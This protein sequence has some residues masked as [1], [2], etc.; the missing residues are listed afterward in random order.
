[1]RKVMRKDYRIWRK[2]IAC[3][4]V[5][6]LCIPV[7]EQV[8]A[9]SRKN[10]NYD[11]MLTNTE[12]TV[13]VGSEASYPIT[14]LGGSVDSDKYK[15]KSSDESIAKVVDSQVQGVKEGTANVKL[16]ASELKK[17][18]TCKVTVKYAELFSNVGGNVYAG[19]TYNLEMRGNA[20][21]T[22]Y[23]SSNEKIAT[24]DQD[25]VV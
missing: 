13:Y 7:G 1:M 24:V 20:S 3:I 2:I 17:T 16:Y 15:I 18:L 4:L 21:G 12:L 25:G 23:I 22:Q 5:V 10:V 8:K 6:M 19:N 14:F 9:A 11:I